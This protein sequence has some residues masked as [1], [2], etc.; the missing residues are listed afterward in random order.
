M[1]TPILDRFTQAD[2]KQKLKKNIFTAVSFKQI[3]RGQFQ[4]FTYSQ[5]QDFVQIISIN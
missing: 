5:L 1:Y 3:Y 4:T 2:F